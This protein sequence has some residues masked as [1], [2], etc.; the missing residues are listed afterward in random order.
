LYS[1]KRN[2]DLGEEALLKKEIVF[3]NETVLREEAVIK[4][5]VDAGKRQYLA[6]RPFFQEIV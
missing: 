2:T 5:V 3:R 6:M 1:Q 4:E